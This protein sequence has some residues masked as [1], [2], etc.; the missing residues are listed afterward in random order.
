MSIVLPEIVLGVTSTLVPSLQYN[1]VVSPLKVIL[2]IATP[3]SSNG[4]TVR[5][6]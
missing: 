2:A 1:V 6:V 3:E 4:S 5:V